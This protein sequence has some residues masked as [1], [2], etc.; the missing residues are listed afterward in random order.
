[1]VVLILV[2]SFKIGVY[3]YF[4]FANKSNIQETCCLKIFIGRVLTEV[5]KETS[6]SKKILIV[7][8]RQFN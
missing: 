3:Y 5:I 1:M 8:C 6:C 2:Y 7:A 4:V